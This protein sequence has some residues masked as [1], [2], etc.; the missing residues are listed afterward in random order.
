MLLNSVPVPATVTEDVGKVVGVVAGGAAL[1]AAA[2]LA[3]KLFA[4]GG[5]TRARGQLTAND[6]RQQTKSRLAQTIRAPFYMK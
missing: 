1:T 6:N 4:L 5:L 3:I 2:V